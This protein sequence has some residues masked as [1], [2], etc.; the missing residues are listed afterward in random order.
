VREFTVKQ[1]KKF[2]RY[3]QVKL[4]V[5]SIILMENAGR[6]TA[7][8]AL[9]MLGKKKRVLVVCGVGNNGGD[10]FVAARHLANAGKKVAIYI[11]GDLAKLKDDPRINLDILRNL[12]LKASVPF[13]NEKGTENFILRFPSLLSKADLIIDAVFGIGIKSKVRS[14]MSEVIE[15]MNKTGKPILAVDVPSGLDADTGRPLGVAIKAKKTVTFVAMKKGFAKAKRYCG[16]IVVR[17]I[18]VCWK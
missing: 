17:D 5:P 8:V 9:K 16:K 11:V 6:S 18:G 3:A 12:R 14:P 4:G 7:E 10:G 13:G 2:D 1:A 15:S